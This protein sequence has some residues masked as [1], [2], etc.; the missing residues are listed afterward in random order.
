MAT[1][2]LGEATQQLWDDALTR[3]LHLSSS[4]VRRNSELEA[5]VAELE[6]EL[7][8][9]KQAHA[10]ALEANEAH[11]VQI[12][13]LNRQISNLDYFKNNQSPLILCV[14]NGNELCF[15]RELLMQGY[16]GGRLA[17]QEITKVI[18][19]HL[20]KEE[21]YVYGRLSFWITIYLSKSEVLEN[22]LYHNACT[23]PHFTSF[24]AGFSQASAR[25]CVVD[26]GCGKDAVESKIKEYLQTFIRFPQTIR[27]FF[28]GYEPPSYT[29][30]FDALDQEQLLGKI[31]LLQ[32]NDNGP[33]DGQAMHPLPKLRLDNVFMNERLQRSPKRLSPL[34]TNHNNG[35]MVSNGGLISPQSPVSRS[36]G[37]AIDPSLPLHKQ[38]PPPCNEHYLMTCSKGAG[39]CKYS[40]D[41]LL[42][43][44]QLAQLANNAKKA[45]CNWLKNGTH[46]HP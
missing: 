44:E 22:L 46:I 14:L 19:E 27:V 26:V 2:P 38:N 35:T 11:N 18:A 43:P 36:S 8:V 13:A 20:T 5:R 3:L 31:A 30:L 15:S 33:G 16:Q 34:S 24:L 6:L 45:P 39:I 32:T 9:W 42:T 7:H 40:H 21:V 28:G 25:F 17:A 23:E 29:A 4:T 10:S 37:R 41:Y 1:Q 12:A